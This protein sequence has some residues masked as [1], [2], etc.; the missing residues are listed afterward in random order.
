M[1]EPRDAAM[2]GGG[3]SVVTTLDEG[4]E[5]LR[6]LLDTLPIAVFVQFEGR[7]VYA[8]G[9]AATLVDVPTPL[10]LQGRLIADLVHETD[11]DKVRQRVR[12]VLGGDSVPP[13]P[14]RIVRVDGTV[15]L[16]EGRPVRIRWQGRPAVAAVWYDLTEHR[17]SA[18]ELERSE[19]RFRDFAAAASD[20]LWETDAERRL[21]YLSDRLAEIVSCP[22]SDWLGKRL[23]DIPGIEIDPASRED[24]ETNRTAGQPFR[25]LRLQL[26]DH[27]GQRRVMEL[28]GVPVRDSGGTIVGY[29]GVGRDVTAAVESDERIRWLAQHDSLTGLANRGRFT[30][31]LEE[32]IKAARRSQSRFAV[33]LIDLDGFKRINDTYGHSAGDRL[34]LEAAR[35]LS[36]AIRETDLGARLGGDEFAILQSDLKGFGDASTLAR[37]LLRQLAKPVDIGERQVTI[38]ASC[39]IAIWPDDGDTLSGLLRAADVAL[40]RAKAEGGNAMLFFVPHMNEEVTR[41]RLLEQELK[42]ALAAGELELHYQPQQDLVTGRIVGVEALARWQHGRAGAVSPDLFVSIAEEYGHIHALGGWVLREACRQARR[43]VDAGRP[44]LRVSVNLSPLELGRHDIAA[45]ILQCA[46]AE[47]LPAA[48]LEVEITE[49][50]RIDASPRLAESLATLSEA[51][52]TIAIDDFGTGYSNLAV[53]QNLA[54]HKLKIDRSFVQGLPGRR[55]HV[56]ITRTIIDIAQNLGLEVVAEGV[57]TQAQADELRRLGCRIVQGYLVAAALTAEACTRL[58]AA[59]G[60]PRRGPD[61]QDAPL[62]H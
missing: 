47:G 16:V 35:R 15:R 34:L 8:N 11:R 54:V 24:Y 38:G 41:R 51:G 45:E 20:W 52:V 9:A 3:R 39:G 29:R 18:A 28:S 26:Q 59:D 62:D 53:L 23:V 58:L 48:N 43:W 5:Q 33:L 49:R 56:A 37:R 17:R 36:R 14:L 21:V 60:G 30:E 22:P 50:T 40:Y 13:A 25:N 6:R 2:D 12:L 27:A 31:R 61:T 4:E 46:A 57:E 19:A 55:E 10:A 44:D 1:V 7:I 32:A 42:D